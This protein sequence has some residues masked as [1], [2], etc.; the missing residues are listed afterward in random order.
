MAVNLLC[1][2][3]ARQ[4]SSLLSG[5]ERMRADEWRSRQGTGIPLFMRDSA[6]ISIFLE[7][8]RGFHNANWCIA[9]LDPF[10]VVPG[11]LGAREYDP[12]R[13]ESSRVD[14]TGQLSNLTAL[15]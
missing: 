4:S 9:E 12:A 3:V 14:P 8:G 13:F 6:L 1:A 15:G 11:P 10:T 5:L 7:V 2:P